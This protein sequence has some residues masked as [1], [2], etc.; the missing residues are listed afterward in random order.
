VSHFFG[1]SEETTG[2]VNRGVTVYKS[3]QVVITGGAILFPLSLMRTFGG[4]RYFS[5]LSLSAL[6][7]SMLVSLL[8]VLM[9]A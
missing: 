3:M 2:D 4:L 9:H 5:I 6:F 8:T 7:F 1:V